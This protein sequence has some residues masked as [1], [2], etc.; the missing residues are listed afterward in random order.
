MAVTRSDLR[1]KIRDKLHDWWVSQDSISAYLS[2]ATT[3]GTVTT[4]TEYHEG[5]TVEMENE[6]LRITNISSNTLTFIRGY[7]GTTAA[8]HSSGT[9]TY[10]INSFSTREYNDAISEAFR[11]TFP[12]ISEPYVGDIRNYKSRWRLDTCDSTAGWT[13]SSDATTIATD[14]S[15]YKEGTASLKLGAA[16]SAGLASYAKNIT[17]M[18]ATDFEYLNFWIYIDNKL[19]TADATY[20]NVNNFAEVRIGNDVGNYGYINLRIDEVEDNDWTLLNLNL[21]DFSSSGT[22]DKTATDYIQLIINDSQSITSGDILMDE[23]YLSKYP[24]TTNK[25]KY[26]LPTNVF[27]VSSVDFFADK[28]SS[29]FY[30]ENRWMIKDNYLIFD[31]LDFEDNLPIRVTGDKMLVIPSSDSTTIDLNDRK[32]ELVILYATN[33]L[34]ERLMAEK[35]RFTRFSSKLNKEEG[36]VIDVVRSLNHYRSRYYELLSQFQDVGQPISMDYYN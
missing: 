8:A 22:W 11:G 27:K 4:G 6:V 15:D 24:V 12:Y 26:R 25:L 7:K 36:S 14:T 17:S 13:A 1:T 33:Y 2:A 21:Q 19:D 23:W 3:T 18:D 35:T 10:I 31:K 5:D 20:Y 29:I 9:T 34:F 28:D 16:Y 32:E 30:T